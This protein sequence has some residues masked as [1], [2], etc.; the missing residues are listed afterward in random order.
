MQCT[1]SHFSH[2]SSCRQR[3]RSP[4]PICTGSCPRLQ[5]TPKVCLNWEAILLIL[6][7][8]FF[9]ENVRNGAAFRCI[10]AVGQAIAYG[11]NTQTTSDPIIGLYVASQSIPS[12]ISCDNLTLLIQWCHIRATW[13]RYNSNDYACQ[14]DSRSNSCWCCSWA[15]RSSPAETWECLE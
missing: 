10:E 6:F 15:A 13:C 2:I 5:L 9:L 7:Y 4:S 14:L 3:V 1:P 11:M 12:K 8:S